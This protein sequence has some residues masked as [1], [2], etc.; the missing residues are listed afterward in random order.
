MLYIFRYLLLIVI[1]VFLVVNY[2]L[3]SFSPIFSRVFVVY[4]IV[5]IIF[6]NKI[7]EIDGTDNRKKLLFKLVYFILIMLSFFMIIYSHY[8]LEEFMFYLGF[9][10]P[11]YQVVIASMGI[12]ILLEAT[13]IVAGPVIPCIAILSVLYAFYR[14]YNFLRM[15]TE[16]YS[17]EGVFGIAVSIVLS[18]VSIFMLLGN[19]LQQARFGDF[20][21]N[22]GNY[23]VGGTSGG[24]A[25]IAVVTSA[26]FGS[27]SGS[28]VANVSGTGTFTIPLMK[29]MGFTPVL[30]AAVEA[31]AST[32]G[33]IMPPIMAAAAF[34]IAEV[35]E[36]PYIE[37]AK[38]ALL[39]ALAYFY[40]IFISVDSF[41]RRL[42]IKGIPKKDRPNF[43]ESFKS[44]GHLMLTLV[45]LIY[46]LVIRVQPLRAAYFTILFLLPLSYLMKKS[47]L[48]TKRIV[49]GLKNTT[50]NLLIIISCCAVIG[51]ILSMIGL[52]GFGATVANLILGLAGTNKILIL[53]LT[54][55]TC[56]IFGMSLPTTV[57]Y[58]VLISVL[59]LTLIKVGVVP[60]SA[61]LFVLYFA[62]LSGITPPVAM[63]AYT[64]AA[65]ANTNFM[66]TAIET[67]KLSIMAFIVPYIFAY[68]PAMVLQGNYP[69]ILFIILLYVFVLPTSLAFALWGHTMM[70]KISN[71]ERIVHLGF[72]I[73]ILFLT[74]KQ[75]F[76]LQTLIAFIWIVFTIVENIFRFKIVSYLTKDKHEAIK[77]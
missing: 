25:K 12:L 46:L 20:L 55:V 3:Y 58:L 77:E 14:G 72:A 74:V 54:M 61:H 1:P 5:I 2:N 69:G 17:Y 41:S 66:T 27:I 10:T 65:I 63:A 28:A 75:I 56:I 19:M 21:L 23:L 33:Q 48:T 76:P 22:I 51:V 52:T 50:Q 31:S 24:A 6:I 62:S 68:V 39:P 7:E 40:T 73:T 38:A 64:A 43:K 71:I 4:G 18:V 13:R 67:C 11:I 8:K 47:R 44:G 32:G 30:A 45:F 15:I 26:L 60:M 29:K 37:V 59:G 53:F 49:K 9:G 35:L 70:H 42:G 57:S 36:V 16:M 34:I